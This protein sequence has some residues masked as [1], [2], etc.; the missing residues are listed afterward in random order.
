MY[1][2]CN[3]K[4]TSKLPI[5]GIGQML[6]AQC[7]E[8]INPATNCGLALNFVVDEPNESWMWKGMDIMI[9]VL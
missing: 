6:F 7:T 3:G 5:D 8:L 2:Y 1:H 9:A 4:D